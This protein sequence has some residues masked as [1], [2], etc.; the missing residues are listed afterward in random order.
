[1]NLQDK[2]NNIRYQLELLDTI[3]SEIRRDACT[4]EGKEKIMAIL[5]CHKIF[6][7]FW[8]GF[9]HFYRA[10]DEIYKQHYPGFPVFQLLR[11]QDDCYGTDWIYTQDH[12]YLLLRITTSNNPPL[13]FVGFK[14]IFDL[15][16]KNTETHTPETTYEFVMDCVGYIGRAAHKMIT[17]PIFNA[18]QLIFLSLMQHYY[19][20][21]D[22]EICPGLEYIIDGD[23]FVGDYLGD[24]FKRMV[25][26]TN[27]SDPLSVRGNLPVI[28]HYARKK[29]LGHYDWA[30]P[31]P[32]PLVKDLK[33]NKALNLRKAFENMESRLGNSSATENKRIDF[34]CV[35]GVETKHYTTNL[36]RLYGLSNKPVAFFGNRLRF[37]IF[38]SCRDPRKAS[39]DEPY[40]GW[41]D[42]D[43]GEII[44]DRFEDL[45]NCL[46]DDVVN[47]L[48]DNYNFL[49]EKLPILREES[50]RNSMLEYIV[51]GF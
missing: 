20:D 40:V 45:F 4:I 17:L 43:G 6:E 51:E 48:E 23:V 21:C 27:G 3:S 16:N 8:E 2:L 33:S 28:T 49:L 24:D 14:H 13:A 11:F 41:T 32:L 42:F 31:D 1:M 30:E 36:N 29:A 19:V 34:D 10:M 50:L 18:N 25:F 15:H 46:E 39:F 9:G 38:G 35:V 44:Y 22:I 5:E 47:T 12:D 7:S 37:G 26:E